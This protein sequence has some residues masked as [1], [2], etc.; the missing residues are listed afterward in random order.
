ML[1]QSYS[2]D[3]KRIYTKV[4]TLDT[5]VGVSGRLA[6]CLNRGLGDLTIEGMTIDFASLSEPEFGESVESS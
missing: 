6:Y 4:G 5:F 3:C 2:G 1:R